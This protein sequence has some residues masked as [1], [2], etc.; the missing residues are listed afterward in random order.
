MRGVLGLRFL[1]EAVVVLAVAVLVWHEVESKPAIFGVIVGTG[2][3]V[4]LAEWLLSR[5]ERP[6]VANVPDDCHVTVTEPAEG[7][8]PPPAATHVVERPVRPEPREWNLWELE[9][10]ARR[11][12]G[13]DV[14]RDEEQSFLLMYLREF[15]DPG[16]VLPARFDPLVR[17]AFA[18]LLQ[19][20]RP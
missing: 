1:V 9:R 20:A 15:A 12:A 19:P 11:T 5:R 6:V 17:E 18:E 13:A 4:A 3:L 16:G 10:I 2:L 7:D 14:A 8:M